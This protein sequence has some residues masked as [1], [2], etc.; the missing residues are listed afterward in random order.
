MGVYKRGN[1]YWFIKHFKGKRY[2]KSLSTDSRRMAEELYAKALTAILRG[3][4]DKPEMQDFTFGALA[5]EYKKMYCRQKSFRGKN[6]YIRLFC[7]AWGNMPLSGFSTRLVE[8][9]QSAIIEKGNA[10]A[11]ANRHIATIKHMIRKAVDWE[12]TGEETLK[13]IQKV[14]LLPENNK[15]LR[16]LSKGECQALIGFCEPHLKPIVQFALNTGCRKGEILSLK[17]ENVDLKHGFISLILTKN[18]D[19]R[20]LPINDSLRAT[21]QGLKRR[22][23]I[24]YVFYD[25]TNG[26]PYGDIKRSF[27]TAL[28]KAGIR[29]FHFHDL[30]HTFS[31]HLIMG[32]TDITTVS[33]LLGHKSLTMTLRYSHLAPAHLKQ[34]VQSLNY[35]D[36]TTVGDSEEFKKAVTH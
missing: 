3:E 34:A 8:R 6:G 14:K 23:D 9:Y 27:N 21:L 12:M 13:R 35:Y 25:D 30:R 11:T 28:R 2:E 15:R 22:L 24:P 16:Y 20:E 17:W 18:G 31:S 4:Y 10:P 29:D 19:R 7:R 33:R 36:F 5:E 1:V 32:G 26:K